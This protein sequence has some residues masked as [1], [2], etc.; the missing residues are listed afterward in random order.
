MGF[1]EDVLEMCKKIPKGKVATYKEIAIALDCPLAARAAGNAL[2]KNP[3]PIKIP[4]HR[5]ISFNGHIGGYVNGKEKKIELL[6]KE[7]VVVKE[8][9]VDLEEYMFRF[10]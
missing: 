2:H 9:F 4:C 7:G 1:D 5:V 6:E 10:D 8:D 3:T